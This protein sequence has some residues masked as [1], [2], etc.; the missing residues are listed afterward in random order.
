MARGE[1]P[2]PSR[3]M[4]NPLISKRRIISAYEAAAFSSLK[5]VLAY[6]SRSVLQL[7]HSPGLGPGS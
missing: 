1:G 4:S 6:E 2:S 5:W 7:G 3:L